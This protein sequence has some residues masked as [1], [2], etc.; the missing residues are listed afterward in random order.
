[1]GRIDE[2]KWFDQVKL[3][4]TRTSASAGDDVDA[5]HKFAIEVPNDFSL[6]DIASAIQKSSYIPKI[7]FG[8]AT[9]SVTS[10]VPIAVIAQQWPE[11]K[12]V[13]NIEFVRDRLDLKDGTVRAH[14]NYH[15]QIDPDIVLE[16]LRELIRGR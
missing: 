16:I 5:P 8:K 12:I 1:M 7:Q 15:A 10:G 4:L 6:D 13:T 9:W 2:T 3:S 11:P 14:V